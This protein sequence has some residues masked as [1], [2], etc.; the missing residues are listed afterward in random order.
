MAGPQW[1]C[2]EMPQ[3]KGERQILVMELSNFDYDQL[4]IRASPLPIGQEDDCSDGD[5]LDEKYHLG[6][7]PRAWIEVKGGQRVFVKTEDHQNEIKAL[8]AV[9]A[10]E[11]A[12]ISKLETGNR[13]QHFLFEDILKTLMPDDVEWGADPETQQ[14][15]FDLSSWLSNA[16]RTSTELQMTFR[17]MVLGHTVNSHGTGWDSVPCNGSQC[18]EILRCPFP[19]T[20]QGCLIPTSSLQPH[21]Y[22]IYDTIVSVTKATGGN[23]TANISGD[24]S[25]DRVTSQ[26]L[27]AREPMSIASRAHHVIQ[28]YPEGA[29]TVAF[30]LGIVLVLLLQFLY[31]MMARKSRRRTERKRVMA[32]MMRTTERGLV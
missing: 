25:V 16:F 20:G 1:K 4:V 19:G 5:C 14:G 8:S 17:S 22:G 3:P 30:G 21:F 7:L 9:T 18:E 12:A 29:M 24:S 15:T 13:V 28:R 27:L 11:E 2:I 10:I 32:P 23:A 31:R 26:D 6:L